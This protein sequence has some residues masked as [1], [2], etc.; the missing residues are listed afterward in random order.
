MAWS[1]VCRP[2][3]LGGLGISDLKRL[4]WSLRMRWVWL[5]KTEPHRPWA[6]LPLQV[7]SQVQAFF[8]IAL[9]TEVGNGSRTLFW[10]DRW[11]HG[12]CIAD[13]APN[14]LAAVSKRRIKIGTVQEGLSNNTWVT[15]LHGALSVVALVEFLQLW[16]VLSEFSLQPAAEDKH[17]WRFSS[18]G[19]YSAKSAYESL[20]L[21]AQTFG[22]AEIIWKT[23]APAKCHFFMWLVAHNRCWTAD[24]LAKRGL[25][26]PE[27]CPLCDQE[28]EDINHLLTSCVFA[29]QF[30][31]L[32]LRQVGLHSLAPQPD[33]RSFVAWWERVSAATSGLVQRGLNSLIILG[34][35]LIWK[36]RNR[37]VFD[38]ASPNMTQMLILAGEERRLWALA[39]AKGISLLTA[40]MNLF[41]SA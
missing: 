7:P 25:P 12:L 23:W 19:M 37:C 24:R 40:A 13:L 28:D 36:H 21:G 39:G 34:A 22:P 14:L 30:W 17:V 1:T 20:F 18:N 8:S 16:D 5:K 35:W 31:F 10:A 29:R 3:D 41:Q 33:D 11:I 26:K 6:S 27:Q 32:F 15:D 2:V 38:K 4:I 9:I